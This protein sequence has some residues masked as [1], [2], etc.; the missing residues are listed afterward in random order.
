MNQRDL[1]SWPNGLYRI[2]W[3]KGGTSLAAI[4]TCADGRRWIAP[5]N[6][7]TPSAD[8]KTW[9]AVARIGFLFAK[10]GFALNEMNER[11]GQCDV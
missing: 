3:R 9:R 11:A 10:T 8:A 4:G 2:F 7:V 6:W 1:K 5:S